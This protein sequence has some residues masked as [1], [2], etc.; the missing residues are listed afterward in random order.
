MMALETCNNNGHNKKPKQ[1]QC[2]DE[3]NR[4]SVKNNRNWLPFGR[5]KMLNPELE[6]YRHF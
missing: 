6:L 4:Q 1:M 2:K 3:H 5:K